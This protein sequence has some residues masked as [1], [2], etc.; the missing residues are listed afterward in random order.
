P[1]TYT[2]VALPSIGYTISSGATAAVPVSAGATATALVSYAGISFTTYSVTFLATGVSSGA[3]WWINLGG[4]NATNTST[5][6]TSQIVFWEPGGSTYFFSVY[7]TSSLTPISPVGEVTVGAANQTVVLPFTA[8]PVTL[9][10]SEHGFPPGS[11]V[12]WGAT[13]IAAGP[14]AAYPAGQSGTSSGFTVPST[15]STVTFNVSASTLY[16]YSAIPLQ[17]WYT[18]GTSGSGNVTT[19]GSGGSALIRFAMVTYAQAFYEVGLPAATS[20]SV[21]A[22]FTYP[23]T[24]ATGYSEVPSLSDQLSINLPNGTATY[25][26][27]AAA[28]FS[29][30]SGTLV[31]SAAPGFAILVFTPTVSTY[32]VTFSQSGLPSGDSWTVYAGALNSTVTSGS[33]SFTLPNGTYTYAVAVP[34]G[35]TATPSGGSFSVNGGAAGVS[36]KVAANQVIVG[37]NNNSSL[38]NLAYALIGL[39]V[40]LAVIFLITTLYFARRKPPTSNPPQSWQST[41]DSS[42]MTESTDSSSNPPPT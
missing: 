5:G 33:V 31:V 25:V 16:N 19:T 14:N 21:N 9:T 3:A 38:S 40:A 11:G 12:A 23:G 28:G 2:Y 17:G 36:L 32:T 24:T 15:T 4:Y 35:Y 1:A 27:S 8:S 7:T 42:T 37:N 13:V 6:S 29:A 26:V 34:T 39:F 10:I 41:S 18:E 30:P 22:T 20:W